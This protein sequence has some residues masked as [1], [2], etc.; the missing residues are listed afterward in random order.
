MPIEDPE[1]EFGSFKRLLFYDYI[2]PQGFD[3]TNTQKAS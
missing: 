2:S 1:G 3:Y